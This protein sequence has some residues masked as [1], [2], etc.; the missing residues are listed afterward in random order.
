MKSGSGMLCNLV[1]TETSVDQSRSPFHETDNFLSSTSAMKFCSWPQIK[2]ISVGN[3]VVSLVTSGYQPI[4]NMS[5]KWECWTAHW[6]PTP[7]SWLHSLFWSIPISRY[8]IKLLHFAAIRVNQNANQYGSSRSFVQGVC[9]TDWTVQQESTSKSDKFSNLIRQVYKTKQPIM[10]LSIIAFDS[11]SRHKV[12][13][14]LCSVCTHLF[15]RW[16][17]RICSKFC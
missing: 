8:S 5:S 2:L 10:K 15:C 17:K 4:T 9:H 3:R 16:F 14:K 6:T 1:S 12:I 7:H 11:H 13:K